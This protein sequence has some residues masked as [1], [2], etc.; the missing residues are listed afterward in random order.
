MSD[1]AQ[2]VFLSYASQDAEAARRLCEALREAGLEVWFDQSELR[3]GDSWDQKIKRRI[4]ECALFLPIISAATQARREG[5]F[6]LEWK[7]AEDRTHLMAKGTPFLVPVCIDDTKD[8]E[9]LVPD[10]F[11][12]VQWTRLPGGETPPKFVERVTQLLAGDTTPPLP[13]RAPA[14]RGGV[15]GPP[16]APPPR[17]YR[18][19]GNVAAIGGVVMGVIFAFRAVEW[20]RERPEK[21]A[22]A[23]ATAVKPA[24][25]PRDPE[26]RRALALVDGLDSTREDFRLADEI[27]ARAA[28][29][30]PTDPEV[31]TVRAR[32]H[33]AFVTRNFD[34]SA[35]R[36]AQAKRFGER[37]VQLAP[38]NPEAHYALSLFLYDRARDIA[39]S[40]AAVRR[41]C[42]LAPDEPR[43]HRQLLRAI[44]RQRPAEGFAFGAAL[45]QR[46]PRD[47]LLHYDL[48]ILHR[49]RGDW[50]NFERELDATLA[51]APIANAINW[52]SRAA[53]LRGNL[54]EMR[55]WLDQV[56]SRT[57]TEER[58]V[59]SSIIYA[60]LSGDYDYGLAALRAFA[61]PWFFDAFYYSG[62]ASLPQ[63]MLL[64]QQGKTG[65]ARL[66][67]QEAMAALARH[68][69]EAPSDQTTHLAEI[70]TLRGLAR[71]DEARALH[72]TTLET[73]QRPYRVSGLAVW[74][75]DVI[76]RCLML[77][78]RATAVQLIR[79]AAGEQEGRRTIVHRMRADARMAP[80]RDDPEIAA[81]LAEPPE[82]G[83]KTNLTAAPPSEAAQLVARALALLAKTGFTRDD[84]VVAEDFAKRATEKEP[85]N[86]A[87]WGARAGVQ[88]A[89]ILRNWDSS[90]KRRQET[91][92]LANKAL[93]LDA[94][95]PEAQLALA[96]VLRAQGAAAQAE[97]FLRRALAAHPAHTRLARAL[98]FTMF[99]AGKN[100]EAMAVLGAAA[101]LAP[102]D[103][104]VRY[105]LA[106]ANVDYGGRGADPANVAGALE[107]LDAAI[108]IQPF[109]SAL[110]LKATL[111]GGWRGDLPGMRA[112]LDQLEAL[113][114]AERSEDRAVG[115]S[116]WAGLLERQPARVETAAAVTAR[117]YLEDAILPLRPTAWSLALAHRLAGKEA[118]ARRNW[119]AGETVLRQRV[120]ESPANEVYQVELAITLAWLEQ[121]EEAERLIAAI[122]PVWREEPGVGRAALL[123]RYHGAAGQAGRAA[124]WL[125]RALDRTVFVSRKAVS[126][127]PW[128]DKVRGAPEF[129]A[130]VRER[131]AT[132]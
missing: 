53:L 107:Q 36:T 26:L 42:E 13:G 120:K 92:T 50:E 114:L 12:T 83:T 8:W 112:T 78:D 24:A 73:L 68:R 105:D 47:A 16:P 93:A 14:E 122:E 121:R 2:A 32:V 94:G 44:N 70:W 113:P 126:L 95:E 111:L 28:E 71:L 29:R 119:Q 100:S 46:F 15:A 84:L 82:P 6:R 130:V 64:E 9:A 22:P 86:A 72:R 4:K 62:P 1:P 58:T 25:F 48:S 125:A 65:Q 59:I 67:Y 17:R 106:M 33:S 128:W 118:L 35:D 34:F 98:G 31:V 5:Y 102:R 10:S 45:V 57:R 81:L 131:E 18:W 37:A 40:E 97:T 74:W 56:P 109:G 117:N 90:E 101:R 127:D 103:P 52:K 39:R 79:E 19:I 115:L 43:Y 88:A 85:D 49:N 91:Q 77:G 116:M 51:L 75:I 30:A 110:L 108:A 80:F 20:Y 27:S 21:M 123:A 11:M 129:E 99:L 96:Q 89:W 76:P 87:T 3:G 7:L 41:A 38:E 63:A 54:A 104:V 132:R 124:E 60:T 61:E 69:Q 55:Q 66:Q 23:A